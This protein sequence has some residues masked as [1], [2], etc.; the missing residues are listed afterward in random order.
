MQFAIR[1][2]LG[3]Q[4]A[5]PGCTCCIVCQ[6]RASV[7]GASVDVLGNQA[8]VCKYGGYK[9]IRHSRLVHLLRSILRE[10]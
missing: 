4:M 6:S 5:S 8:V 10:S 7:C 1:W 3:A 2:R 9:T